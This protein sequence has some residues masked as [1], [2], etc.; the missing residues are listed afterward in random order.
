MLFFRLTCLLASY[1]VYRELRALLVAKERESQEL[2]TMNAALLASCS[3][4]KLRAIN[5]VLPGRAASTHAETASAIQHEGLSQSRD[6]QRGES[7]GDFDKAAV[8]PAPGDN[9]DEAASSHDNELGGAAASDGN[10]D[11]DDYADAGEGKAVEDGSEAADLVGDDAEEEA[12][13]KEESR[14]GAADGNVRAG[15][16]SS[17]EP[18]AAGAVSSLES[19]TAGSVSSLEPL[20]GGGSENYK[21]HM[22]GERLY[23]L[24]AKTQP[25]LAGKI[26][27]VLLEMD[28]DELLHLLASPEALTAKTQEALEV[29]QDLAFPAA[30]GEE[31][32][33][34]PA[35][36]LARAQ[37]L[38]N[39]GDLAFTKNDFGGDFSSRHANYYRTLVCASSVLKPLAC[40]E[41]KRAPFADILC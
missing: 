35:D 33:S 29:L 11:H 25:T 8:A 40:T 6:Q 7:S 19:L 13:V 27:G 30:E 38:N 26:T 20:A 37:A 1:R 2:R 5:T 9:G 14:E 39:A 34:R 31:V 24:V 17:L 4:D 21:K 3:F 10:S 16:V 15:S 23:R 36:S 22:L 28:H 41:R 18:V 32:A 12:S